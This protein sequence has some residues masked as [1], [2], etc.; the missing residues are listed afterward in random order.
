MTLHFHFYLLTYVFSTC[1]VLLRGGYNTTKVDSSNT[2]SL[3]NY[4]ALCA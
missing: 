2:I 3:V 1:V 4:G